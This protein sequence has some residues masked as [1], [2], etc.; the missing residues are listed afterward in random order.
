MSISPPL[1]D[2]APPLRS[3]R[4]GGQKSRA[5]R[6]RPDCCPTLRFGVC[7]PLR[8]MSGE[9]RG[10]KGVLERFFE[11]KNLGTSGKTIWKK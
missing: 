8:K 6:V 1:I 3:P 10:S 4:G 11:E 9:K 2:I 7:P 5:L